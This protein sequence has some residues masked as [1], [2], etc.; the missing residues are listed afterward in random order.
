MPYQ[1]IKTT[2]G[3]YQLKNKETNV[4]VK[5]KFLTRQSAKKAGLNYHRYAKRKKSVSI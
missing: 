1:I 3:K 4:V 2:D 5:K